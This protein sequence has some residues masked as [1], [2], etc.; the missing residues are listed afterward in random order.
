MPDLPE[1]QPP[2]VW[3]LDRTQS[4]WW[5]E[6]HGCHRA[7]RYVA[8]AAVIMP[9]ATPAILPADLLHVIPAAQAANEQHIEATRRREEAEA[10]RLRANLAAQVAAAASA[11]AQAAA[12]EVKT[13]AHLLIADL[14]RSEAERAAELSIA[15]ET[16][17]SVQAATRT[18]DQA[19]AAREE[20]V[21]VAAVAAAVAPAFVGTEAA[22]AATAHQ[23]FQTQAQDLE[24]VSWSRLG[25]AAAT[26]EAVLAEAPVAEA[27]VADPAAAT[28][29][30]APAAAAPPPAQ[31]TNTG[32]IATF[33]PQVFVQGMQA[34]AALCPAVPFA[35]GLGQGG[36]TA[37]QQRGDRMARNAADVEAIG[38][39]LLIQRGAS[40]IQGVQQH[41]SPGCPTSLATT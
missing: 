19:A 16:L 18:I 36:A 24:D 25:P 30:E 35:F 31:T 34:A 8:P 9:A 22:P 7:C 6:A 3:R 15:T 26:P 20:A 28:V 17:D 5:Y 29:A 12:N 23:A 37:S 1:G 32:T 33:A 2:I 4:W 41:R 13:A 10:L 27:P 38:R 14:E 21:A 11:A 40:R 39:Q